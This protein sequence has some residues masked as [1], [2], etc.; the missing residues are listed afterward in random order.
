VAEPT[1][2]P[3]TTAP[4]STSTT[5]PRATATTD[6]PGG[7]TYATLPDGTPVPILAVFDVDRVTLGGAVP[8][9]AAKDLLGSLAV[10]NSKTPDVAVEN[11]LTIDPSVPPSIG[12]RVIELTSA[13]FPSGSADVL[14]EHAAELNRIVAVMNAL[15]NITT[16]VIG[17]SDQI[18]SEAT[19]FELSEARAR[20]VVT[21]LV[22]QGIAPSRL[23]SR[24]VG[25]LDLLSINND[26]TSLALNRRTEFVISGLIV[27]T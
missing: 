21:Y 3:T 11:L 15:P 2:E 10:A 6:A 23:S 9:Q 1:T 5:A 24:G 17:H 18:G 14:P 16:L 19:N 8:S 26:E 20:S 27:G 22:S 12:V 13:R 25:E 4:R 7:S